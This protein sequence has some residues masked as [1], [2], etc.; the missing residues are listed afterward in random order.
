MN[1]QRSQSIIVLLTAALLP[2]AAARAARAPD[3]FEDVRETF[4]RAYAQVDAAALAGR[5]TDSEALRTYPLYP[6]LQAARIR[7]ALLDA[8][9]TLGSFDQRAATFA[10]YHENEPVGRDLRRVWLASLAERGHWAEFL[11]QYR[12]SVAD[13][14]LECQS[15]A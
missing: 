13:D 1:S 14:A 10:M 6:Y 11:Q 4:K 3:L 12:D 9:D 15:F 5:S 7:R 2:L 8:G